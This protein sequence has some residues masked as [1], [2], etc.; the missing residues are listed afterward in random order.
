L[1]QQIK[2]KDKQI[3]L[4]E[5][6]NNVQISKVFGQQNSNKESGQNNKVDLSDKENS[7]ASDNQST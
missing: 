6:I 2:E 1:P 4:N 5:N 7:R 3:N